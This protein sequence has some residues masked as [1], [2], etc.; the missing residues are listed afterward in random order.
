[1][2]VFQADNSLA[3]KQ[4]EGRKQNKERI[5]LTICCNGDGSNR[6][7]LWVIGKYKNPCCFKNI[8]KNTLG[9]RNNSTI[10]YLPPNATSKI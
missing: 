9:Y 2:I 1:M 7:P 8:N 4:L 3:S 5:T 6:L 10:F